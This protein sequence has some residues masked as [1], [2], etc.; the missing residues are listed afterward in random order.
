MDFTVPPCVQL[1]L[2]D[3]SW[4]LLGVGLGNQLAA[5]ARLRALRLVLRVYRWFVRADRAS[6]HVVGRWVGQWFA[7]PDLPDLSSLK[8]L[9][10][11][12]AFVGPQGL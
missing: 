1:R 6:T 7:L 10:L 2:V 3:D 11:G 8:W 5:A 9:D 4:D 12:P